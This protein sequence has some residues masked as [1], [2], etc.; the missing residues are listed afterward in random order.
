MSGE[1]KD[2]PYLMCRVYFK[3]YPSISLK[4]WWLLTRDCSN[5]IGFGYDSTA[6]KYLV[7]QTDKL[8]KDDV[9]K[10]ILD[11]EGLQVRSKNVSNSK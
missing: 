4:K 10:F 1:V 5:P 7:N 8:L 11:S 2:V 3:L 9:R 6:V